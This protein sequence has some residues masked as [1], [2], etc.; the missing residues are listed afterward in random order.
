M[1]MPKERGPGSPIEIFKG[2]HVGAYVGT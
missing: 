2:K 1:Y